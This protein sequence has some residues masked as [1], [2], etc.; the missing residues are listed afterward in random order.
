MLKIKKLFHTLP[1]VIKKVSM[2][3]RH[4]ISLTDIKETNARVTRD[5]PFASRIIEMETPGKLREKA[6]K[7]FQVKL[8]LIQIVDI[9]SSMHATQ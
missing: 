8:D 9:M 1:H 6:R 7:P 3:Q 4:F 5:S 2:S